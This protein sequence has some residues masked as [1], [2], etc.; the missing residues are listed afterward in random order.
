MEKIR[1]NLGKKI[2]RKMEGT[3]HPHKENTGGDQDHVSDN[4]T[5]EATDPLVKVNGHHETTS[6]SRG[7]HHLMIDLETMGKILMPR[8]SQ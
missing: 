4:E 5:G 6:T 1:M 3:E 7:W 8:L 2:R